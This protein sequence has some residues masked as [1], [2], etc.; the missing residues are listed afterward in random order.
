[1]SLRLQPLEYRFIEPS[2]VGMPTYPIPSGIGEICVFCEN[3]GNNRSVVL[4]ERL[5][6]NSGSLENAGLIIWSLDK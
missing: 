5:C 6:K 4:V 3:G 2:N 1:M